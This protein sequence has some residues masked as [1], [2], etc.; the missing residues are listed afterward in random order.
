MKVGWQRAGRPS[1]KPTVQGDGQRLLWVQWRD[2]AGL[3]PRPNESDSRFKGKT[4]VPFL[5]QNISPGSTAYTVGL[6]SFEGLRKLGSNISPTLNRC[7]PHSVKT[8]SRLSHL[9]IALL[10]I[11]SNC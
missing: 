10:E 3:R 2:V 6:K 9:P 4:V 1:R 7:D 8:R 5:Y 11:S